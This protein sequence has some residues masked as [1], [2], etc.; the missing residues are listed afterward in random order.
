MLVV[1]IA[2]VYFTILYL[3]R[4]FYQSSCPSP[5]NRAEE[6]K[7]HYIPAHG[8]TVQNWIVI[9]YS[10]C[11][12][13][14]QGYTRPTRNQNHSQFLLC[15]STHGENDMHL[16]TQRKASDRR[17]PTHRRQCYNR[18]TIKLRYSIGQKLAQHVHF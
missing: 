7:K 4:S 6:K 9:A 10:I 12:A 15:T 18:S 1:I 5:T 17:L 3:W 2:H 13:A 8:N 16:E 11:S 14:R